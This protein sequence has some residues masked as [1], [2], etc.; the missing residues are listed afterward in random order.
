[1]A[2]EPIL[3]YI[4]TASQEEAEHIGRTLVEERLAACAN[5]LPQHLSFYWWQGRLQEDYEIIVIAKTRRELLDALVARVLELH[6][7][8]C[9]CVVALPITGGHAAYLQW[10]YQ[11]TRAP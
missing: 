5:I 6:S 7:Y 11:E 9:P 10:V 4:T 2:M 1:M 8:E 3:I